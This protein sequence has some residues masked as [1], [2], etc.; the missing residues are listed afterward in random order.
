M[1]SKTDICNRALIKLG[2]A[3]IRDIDT[4]ESPQGTL[5]K[6]VYDAMLDE[7]LRQA[8]WNFAVTR[9]SLNQDNSGS[10][11]YEWSY[12]YILPTLPPVIKIIS[13]ENNN[14]FKIESGF[15]VSNSGK[16]NLKYIGRV[17][18]PNLYDSLF[19]HTFVLRIANEI[20]FAL[21]SQ[22]GLTDS[23]YKQYLLAIEEAKNQNS[24]DDNELPIQDSTWTNSRLRA[25]TT[26]PTFETIVTP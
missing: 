20:S 12:R 9:Q 24:Q 13:V 18:D 17:T 21:T 14:P 19:I 15:L 23:L 7:V 10:P 25:L 1:T 4:D 8:E 3:T 2:K 6:A 16:I 22:T 5:C 11:L 26:I